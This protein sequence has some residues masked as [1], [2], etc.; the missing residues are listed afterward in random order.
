ML[1][2]CCHAVFLKRGLKYIRTVFI[3]L[4]VCNAYNM[5][6][7]LIHLYITIDPNIY[8]HIL[9]CVPYWDYDSP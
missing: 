3:I 8:T 5:R 9:I 7:E 4:Y 6:Y 1:Q 2:I